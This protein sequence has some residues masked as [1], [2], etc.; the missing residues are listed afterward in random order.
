MMLQRAACGVRPRV[1]G[2]R[3]SAPSVGSSGRALRVAPVLRAEKDDKVTLI[4]SLDEDAPNVSGE[5]CS[6]DVSGK[7]EKRTIGEMETEFLEA[8]SA[9]YYDGK[10]K[11]TDA[12]F[13]NLREELLWNGSSVAILSSDEMKFL[14]ARLGYAK[15]Q[16][17]MSDD[18]FDALR[19]QLRSNN[20]VVSAQ[21]PRCS[22]RTR[23][24]YS[25]AQ[26]DIARM[27][28]L[29]VPAVLLLLGFVF[30]IDDV[31][32]FEIT[33]AI[34]LPPPWGLVLLWGVLLPSLYVLSTAVTNIGFKD[35]LILKGN[36]PDCGHENITY[37]G[38]LLTVPGNRGTNVVDCGKC[39]AGLTFDQ[40]KRIIMIDETPEEKQKKAA[41]LAAKKAAS[42][43]KKAAKAAKEA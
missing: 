29:N 21:G 20:S 10:A 42:A 16:P 26:Y 22:I 18:E 27:T 43:A 34:E 37:F 12:E 25:D 3:S 9:Y 4:A 33:Q 24:L 13:E 11:L 6:I 5:Y 41:A 30:A 14:E 8:M 32:G 38:D 15:G 1:S 36:C 19:G 28:A 40:N 7:K 35:G 31:T 2:W 23:K 39:G 17:I